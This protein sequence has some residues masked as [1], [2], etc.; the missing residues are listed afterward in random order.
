MLRTIVN[1]VRDTRPEKRCGVYL[2]NEAITQYGTK[3]FAFGG[4]LDPKALENLLAEHHGSPAFLI[5]DGNYSETI[6]QSLL[7]LSA[8]NQISIIMLG[9][10]VNRFKLQKSIGQERVFESV[11][12]IEC[13]RSFIT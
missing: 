11:D 12:V 4:K 7:R 5:T 10:D 9:A 1:F 13:I 3:E 2:W 6:R 8:T